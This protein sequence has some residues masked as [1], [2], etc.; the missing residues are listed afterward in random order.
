MAPMLHSEVD[1][2]QLAQRFSPNRVIM[3][4]LLILL[5]L[6]VWVL[7][8]IQTVVPCVKNVSDTRYTR[9]N[10]VSSLFC[11]HFALSNFIQLRV[12]LESPLRQE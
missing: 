9:K 5:Y 1:S 8:A 4:K 10:G 2:L 6:G 3:T 7:L 12:W 11:S